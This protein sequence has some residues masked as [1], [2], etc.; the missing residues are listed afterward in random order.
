M[1]AG[2]SMIRSCDQGELTDMAR[3]NTQKQ[4]KEGVV[5]IQITDETNQAKCSG[6]EII[7]ISDE[8]LGGV[9][10]VSGCSVSCC[11]NN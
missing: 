11:Q 2:G 7:I 3:Q 5:S 10:T 9:I 8:S 4:S 1:F 6:N